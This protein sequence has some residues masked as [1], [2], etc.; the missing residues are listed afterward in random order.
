[1]N[2]RRSLVDEGRFEDLKKQHE[3]FDSILRDRAKSEVH[4]RLGGTDPPIR[5]GGGGG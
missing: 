5:P 3:T 4:K 2:G 1:M